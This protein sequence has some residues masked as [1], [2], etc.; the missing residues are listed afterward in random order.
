VKVKI[1]PGS[2]DGTKLKVE[3]EGDRENEKIPA[4]VIFTVRQ[5]QH[6]IFNC[7]GHDLEYTAKIVPQEAILGCK[8]HISTLCNQTKV[9]DIKGGIGLDSVQRCVNEGLPYLN[10]PDKQG[11]LLIRFNVMLGKLW[12]YSFIYES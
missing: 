10:E 3:K 7:S 5:E 1:R 6:S 8:L 11:D 9:F 4:D 2:I 12:N